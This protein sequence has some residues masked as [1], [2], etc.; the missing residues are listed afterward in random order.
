MAEAVVVAAA[1]RARDEE[2][3]R[4]GS[5]GRD[6]LLLE[7]AR[8]AVPSRRGIPD[9]EGLQGVVDHRRR[10]R[11]EAAPGEL[12]E[13]VRALR[14]LAELSLEEGRGELVDRVEVLLLFLLAVDL[15]RGPCLLLEGDAGALGEGA[16][17]LGE[18]GAFVLHD[19]V[20]GA[21][22]FLA[23]EAVEV[24]A[25]GVDVEAPRL[26]LVKRTQ[27]DEGFPAALERGHA[28]GDERDDVRSVA[29]EGDG[30]G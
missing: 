16:H 24:A 19:E 29:D 5:H 23:P 11:H 25:V 7:E 8:E 30:L 9:A 14:V 26:L 22:L 15:R 13:G 2:P 18:R 17:G 3:H 6:A 12:V 4:L 10:P 20:D 1:A 28:L 21:A 27:P